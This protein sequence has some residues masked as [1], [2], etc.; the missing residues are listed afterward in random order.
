LVQTLLFIDGTSIIIYHPESNYFKN[1]I[2]GIYV[3]L[4][5]WFKANKLTSNFDKTNFMKF[6]TNIKT[7]INLGISYNNKATEEVATFLSLQIDNNLNWKKH[8]EYIISKL[9]SAC[10]AM[11]TVTPLM[12]VDTL[13]LVNVTF[14]YYYTV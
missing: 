9:S 12:R 2:N 1:T 6:P 8:I 7:C 5:K 11:R 14:V 3:I 4:Q 10:F 13:K